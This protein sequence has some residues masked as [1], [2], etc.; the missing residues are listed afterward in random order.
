MIKLL[1]NAGLAEDKDL[2]D[3]I[4]KMSKECHICRVY[5]RPFLQPVVA[6]PLATEFND[7]V[8]MDIKVYKNTCILHL[9]N[10]VTMFSA[11]AIV[12]LKEKEEIIKNIFKIWISIYGPP[13]KYFSDNGGE[14]SDEN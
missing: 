4:H 10:H 2:I 13:L 3:N 12:K 5:K 8:A 6:A 14:F 7:V 1:S 9:I 11:A